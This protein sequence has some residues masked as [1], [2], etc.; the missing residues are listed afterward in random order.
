MVPAPDGCYSNYRQQKDAVRL[1]LTTG[2]ENTGVGWY[3]LYVNTT[4]SFSTRV[5]GGALAQQCGSNTAPGAAA[6]LLNTTAS[7]NAA[8]GTHALVYNDSGGENTANG[9]FTLFSN[10]S[11]NFNTAVGES[12]LFA[13]NSGEENTA[14]GFP[15]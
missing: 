10:T 12:A 3:S 6:L 14:V 15:R 13:N 2:S 7:N 1:I 4:G 9:A 5:D 8:I 11:G